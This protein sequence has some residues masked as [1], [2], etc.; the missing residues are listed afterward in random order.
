MSDE[1]IMAYFLAAFA[2][3]IMGWACYL[4]NSRQKEKYQDLKKAFEEDFFNSWGKPFKSIFPIEDP[5]PGVSTEA[6]EKAYKEFCDNKAKQPKRARLHKQSTVVTYGNIEDLPHVVEEKRK[7]TL[8][9]A[10]TRSKP[11]ATA[12][13]SVAKKVTKEME[14]DYKTGK[15]SFAGSTAKKDAHAEKEGK[16]VAKALAFD[17]NKA[18]KKK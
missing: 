1:S 4:Y 8:K 14:Y 16:K 7:P 6:Q 9:K 11:M 3:A 12:K 15:K 18:K 2:G 5:I 13:K 10:T 17:I